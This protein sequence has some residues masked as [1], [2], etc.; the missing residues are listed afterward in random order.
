MTT[1]VTGGTGFL[2]RHLVEKLVERG[3]DVR[4]LT[5]SFNLELSDLGVEIVEGSLEN[6]EDIERAIDGATRVYHLAGKVERDRTRAHEM[7]AIHV[8]A[9][10][11]LLRAL[12]DR[13]KQTGEMVEKI[14]YASTS[15]TVGV[16]ESAEFMATDD[17]PPAEQLVRDWP[18]YLSKIYAERVCE[19]FIEH[20]DLPI[21]MMR[22]TLLLGPG[23]RNQSSTGDVVQ[24]LQKKVPATMP[25]GISFVDVRDTADAFIAAMERGEPGATYLLGAAN[26]PL[27]DFFERLEDISGIRAPKLPIPGKAAVAGARFMD[28][29]L[30]AVGKKSELDPASVEMAQY[31]WYI[32]SSRADKDL[33]WRPRP[34]NETLRD[35]VRWIRANHPELADRGASKT[36]RRTPP[37]EFVPKETVEFARKIAGLR[38]S[39]R[40]S[41]E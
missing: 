32:D 2:G 14:V 9:T 18:Y 8:D 41:S 37:E 39:E 10:R 22:P 30:R 31:F 20:H 28:R 29:A 21:V 27:S 38:S 16:G 26:M 5:R 7:Y 6:I 1:L 4:V 3:E 33:D 24:F 35:T 40:K 25:G 11:R 13:A 15:G 36:G 12:S 19:R 17:S 23:D 34:A